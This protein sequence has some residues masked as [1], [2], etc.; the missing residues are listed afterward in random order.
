MKPLK[1][2]ISFLV[3]VTILLSLVPAAIAADNESVL[4]SV[5]HTD[6]DVVT[7]SGSARDV[8]LTAPY[9]SSGTVDLSNGL[10]ITWD[11]AVYKSVVATSSSAAQIGGTAV[12]LTVTYNYKTDVAGTPKSTTLYSVKV[13]EAP[14]VDPV[15][16]GTIKKQQPLSGG[17]FSFTSAGSDNDFENLYAQND[18]AALAFIS[19]SAVIPHSVRLSFPQTFIHSVRP[20]VWR[21][22]TAIS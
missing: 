7:I 5:G 8:T 11:E 14:P 4:L 15:F 13:V 12:T 1:I 2:L 22:L 6:T 9:G 19:L 3:T 20:S 17:V 18:G 10:A 21:I 16:S